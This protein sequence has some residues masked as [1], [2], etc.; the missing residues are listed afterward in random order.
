MNDLRVYVLFNS[1]SVI[2]ERWKGYNERLYVTEPRLR[3]EKFQFP[4]RAGLEP[5]TGRSA[6]QRHT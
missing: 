1:V 6:G 5:R 4:P 2:S 3:L